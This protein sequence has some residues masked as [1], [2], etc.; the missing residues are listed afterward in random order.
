MLIGFC[1]P[2]LVLAG[3]AFVFSVLGGSVVL[4]AE[5]SRDSLQDVAH[6][7]IVDAAAYPWSAVGAIFNSS[8]TEC[9]AVAMA[10]DQVL[11]A[12][13]CLY[14]HRTGYLMQPGSLHVLMGFVRGKYAVD[15]TVRSYHIAAGYDRSRAKEA[16]DNDWAVLMLEHALPP[17]R[18]TLALAGRIPEAGSAVMVGGYG[19]GRAFMMTADPECRVVRPSVRGLVLS[20]CRIAHGYSGGPLLARVD[21][22]D[23]VEIIGI[24]IAM[25]I[26]GPAQVTLTVPAP[27]IRR[28]LEATVP[29]PAGEGAGR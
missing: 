21:G 11:T 14:G 18:A 3:L 12:A 22:T 1:H 23:K 8:S 6:R 24:N 29:S 4:A 28:E 27:S 15:A 2:A 9:T 25:V 17:D 10:P 7:A 19:R 13:H 26:L 5:A 16:R 20:D